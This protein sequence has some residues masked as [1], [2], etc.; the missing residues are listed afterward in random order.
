MNSSH[1]VALGS[2]PHGSFDYDAALNGCADKDERAFRRLYDR[3][4][5]RLLGIALRI[6]RQ[7]DIA[8]DVVHDA[9]LTVWR[10]ADTF[11]PSRGSGRAWLSTIV[12]NLALNRMRG[13]RSTIDPD[14]ALAQ[15]ADSADHPEQALQRVEDG[16]RLREC[17]EQLDA[18]KRT[19]ILLAFVDGYT[20]LQISERLGVGLNTAKS[21]IRRGLVHLK[22]CLQ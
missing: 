6:V 17:L 21:W 13:L 7:R 14:R 3:D 1:D 22:G 10:Q 15:V 16:D 2:N 12:R 11:S 19:C 8:E 18:D 5:A 9:F 4:G 20:Q